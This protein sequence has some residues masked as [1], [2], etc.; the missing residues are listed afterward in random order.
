MCRSM[1]SRT[2]RRSSVGRQRIELNAVAFEIESTTIAGP[3]GGAGRQAE[4]F[5]CCVSATRS[6]DASNRTS[7][8]AR[9]GGVQS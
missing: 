7:R 9:S 2:K 3:L 8:K 1:Y 5:M 4:F 6:T